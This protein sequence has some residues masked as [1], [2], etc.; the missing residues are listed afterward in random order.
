MLTLG[1]AV[2]SCRIWNYY[3]SV[4]TTKSINGVYKQ[5]LTALYSGNGRKLLHPVVRLQGNAH[6]TV[7][8]QHWYI[9]YL[10]NKVYYLFIMKM[11]VISKDIDLLSLVWL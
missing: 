2:Y 4:Q 11:C 7:I 8:L 9:F 5:I 1:E 3:G 6:A 10:L